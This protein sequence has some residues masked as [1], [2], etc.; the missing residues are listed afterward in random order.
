MDMAL[1]TI[2]I[3]IIIGYIL[4]ITGV[5][6][7]ISHRGSKNMES[8]FQAGK[9]LPWYVLGTSNAATMFDITGTMWLVYLLFAYGLKSAWIPWI[10]P[11]FNQIFGMVYLS[12]WLRR[13]NV[14]TGAEWI[15]TRFGSG[16]GA[17]LSHISVVIFAL[18][19]VIGFM[20]Y[21]FEGIGKF[22][23][24]FFPWDISP[25]V[26]A[27]I[28]M[29]VTT[30]Y[31]VT[32]GM[33]SVV[34]CEIIQ[35]VITTIASIIIAGIAMYKISPEMLNAVVPAGWKNLSFGLKLDI[36]WSHLMPSLNNQMEGDGFSLFG[37]VFG[38]ILFKGILAS[39][40]GPCPNYDMQR[41]LSTKNPREASLMSWC[42]SVVQFIPRYLL[43]TSITIIA[44]VFYSHEMLAE[45]KNIDFEQLLPLIINRFLPIG[46]TGLMIAGLLAA[47]MSTFN[48]TVNAGAAY[49]VNDIYKAFINPN[50]SSKKCVYIGYICTI[51]IIVVGIAFGFMIEKIGS[52]TLWIVGIL[53]AGY[54]APNVLKWHWWRLNGYGFFAGMTTGV[55]AALVFPLIWKTNQPL[56]IFPFILIISAIASV[57]VSLMT[58][59]ED[60]EVL[61]KFYTTIR[62][63]GFW[64]PIYKK[65][66]IDEPLFKRNT[67]FKRDMANVA[68]GI[69]WQFTLSLMTI[70]FV[71]KEFKSMF[72]TAAVTIA[73]SIFLYFNWYKKLEKNDNLEGSQWVS[74]NKQPQLQG[75]AIEK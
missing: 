62:P 28:F 66:I 54:L 6:I 52:V 65:V 70:Y 16:T 23:A 44:L 27:L 45:G 8:Y 68:V 17:K 26:Y 49:V 10:W 61:K 19:S 42:V 75:Q 15:R 50:A 72:I 41:V 55:V 56:Y 32:G 14:V 71:I 2:D 39:M 43:I 59:P 3:I 1:H 74:Q 7:F 58:E 30:I 21:A 33:F 25:K 51:S 73:T 24:I 46:I 67:D 4:A 60:S 34:L 47:F 18:V 69:I 57:V 37:I 5:G 9:S 20:S 11:T 29:S 40:A 12:I 31:V 53:Y 64:K 38:L 13:S 22:A 48:G 35:Y 36:D 63:W